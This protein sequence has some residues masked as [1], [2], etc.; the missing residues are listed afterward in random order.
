MDWQPPFKVCYHCGCARIRRLR[1]TA[2]ECEE[3]SRHLFI[4][5]V[6]A[7]ALILVNSENRV[8]LVKRAH[9]PEKGK[10]SLPGGFMD[11]GETAEDGARRETREE[12]GL[13]VGEVNY[14]ASFPNYYA[15]GDT[16]Y[17]VLDL[18]FWIRVEGFGNAQ[19]LD[20]VD[21]VTSVPFDSIDPEQIAFPSVRSALQLFAER[22]PSLRQ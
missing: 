16:E 14:L 6:S 7:V 5:P 2:F 18:F 20:E 22:W 13:E 21:A 15:Y 3:C 8:L 11:P 4:N 9:E 1:P 17:I 19:A 10:L 12:T